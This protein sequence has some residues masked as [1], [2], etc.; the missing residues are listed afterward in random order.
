MQCIRRIEVDGCKNGHRMV[1]EARRLLTL[2]IGNDGI[3][4]DAIW[5]IHTAGSP[6]RVVRLFRGYESLHHL[7]EKYSFNDAFGCMYTRNPSATV[8]QNLR[9]NA[10]KA[11]IPF[12]EIRKVGGK[13]QIRLLRGKLPP[14][15][16]RGAA[17][18]AMVMGVPQRSLNSGICW[19]SAVCF[20]VMRPPL[21]REAVL[22]QLKDHA[23]FSHHAPLWAESLQRPAVAEELRRTIYTEMGLGDKPGIPEEDEGQNGFAVWSM[24][25]S[26]TKMPLIALAVINGELRNINESALDGNGAYVPPPRELALLHEPCMLCIR[27]H[28]NYYTPPMQLI[29][30]GRTFV[31]QS[32]L[33]GSEWCGH[34]CALARG[35]QN[36]WHYMD[37]DAG[38][39]AIGPFSFRLDEGRF[40]EDLQY[41][42]PSSNHS[43]TS[44]FCDMAPHNRS[45]FELQLEG[46]KAEGVDVPEHKSMREDRHK[47]V[48]A[49]W[50]YVSI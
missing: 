30:K 1:I 31:L 47:V 5:R 43:S 48:N 13:R 6:T 50:M 11:G 12:D 34:Q 23:H 17:A 27:V 16:S 9:A 14:M 20:A 26:K 41:V 19:W 4:Q 44:K 21:M 15:A 10:Q 36:I 18:A 22:V 37:S 24:Y 2:Q 45:P 46:L 40:W 25:A 49:D 28:R 33:I 35:D 29:H 8:L 7:L 3:P 39:C 42:L 32:C 38:R